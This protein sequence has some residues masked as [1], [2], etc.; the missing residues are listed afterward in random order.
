MRPDKKKKQ[1]F[2]RTSEAKLLITAASIT[3][4]VAGVALFAANGTAQ[5]AQT[6]TEL[7]QGVVDQDDAFTPFLSVPDSSPDN[8]QGLNGQDDQPPAVEAIPTPRAGSGS[9]RRGRSQPAPMG[10]THSSR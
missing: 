3:A 1:P 2:R 4:T 10:R 9:T 7:V 8:S 6:P 5:T